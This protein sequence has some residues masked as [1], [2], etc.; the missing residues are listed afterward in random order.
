MNVSFKGY[1]YLDTNFVC[2]Y[3]GILPYQSIYSISHSRMILPIA[4]FKVK[5]LSYER[6]T[7]IRVNPNL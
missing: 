6:S 5:I 2:I 1:Y 4:N 3:L 7:T